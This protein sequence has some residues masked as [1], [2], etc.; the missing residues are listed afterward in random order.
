ME[1]RYKNNKK[2]E[3]RC[4]DSQKIL[5]LFMISVLLLSIISLFILNVD[6]LK[7][8]S[9]VPEIGVVFYKLALFNFDKFDL[10]Y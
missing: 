7:L 10:I 5:P 3:V 4:K 6:W 1:C 2:I 8:F 9:R